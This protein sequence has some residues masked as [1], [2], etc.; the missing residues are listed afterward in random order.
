MFATSNAVKS[1]AVPFSFLLVAV[2]TALIFSD[3]RAAERPNFVIIFTDDQGYG[4]LG[5]FGADYVDTP[6]I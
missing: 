2:S 6:R 4:D 1:F 5:C 3:A